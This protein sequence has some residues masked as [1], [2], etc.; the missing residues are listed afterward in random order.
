MA[1]F[2]ISS[3]LQTLANKRGGVRMMKINIYIFPHLSPLPY[4]YIISLINAYIIQIYIYRLSLTSRPYSF[5]SDLIVEY[6]RVYNADELRYIGIEGWGGGMLVL[7][8]R[9][10]ISALCTH[11]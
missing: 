3:A 7:Y 4:I 10:T 2:N 1:L 6:W 8:A 11:K 9:N 5:F